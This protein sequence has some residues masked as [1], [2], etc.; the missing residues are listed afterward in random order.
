MGLFKQ[1]E[2][3]SA[4]LSIGGVY[5]QVPVYERD[6]LLYA[7]LSGGFI[8]LKMDGSTSHPKARL[9]HLDFDGALHRDEL[10]R[11]CLPGSEGRTTCPLE[12]EKRLQLE[13]LI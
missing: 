12:A 5:K 13:G 4:V 10:G 7:A 6:G 1:L 2:G 8:R 3:N 11:L 9:D